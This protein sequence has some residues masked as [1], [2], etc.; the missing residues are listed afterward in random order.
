MGVA[1]FLEKNFPGPVKRFESNHPLINRLMK[2][3]LTYS[4]KIFLTEKLGASKFQKAVF[5]V[6]DIKYKV[7]KTVCPNY[8][9]YSDKLIDW[10]KRKKLKKLHSDIE[11]KKVIASANYQKK[12]SHKEFHREINR[13]YHMNSNRPLEIIRYLEWNKNVHKRGLKSDVIIICCLLIISCLGIGQAAIIIPFELFSAFINF[14]CVNIQ[15]HNIYRFKEKEDKLRKIQ[16]AQ[17]ERNSTKYA[18]ANKLI[19]DKHRE[20][21]DVPTIDDIISNVE[22]IE[23]LQQLRKLIEKQK[24]TNNM[25][26]KQ[27]G[28]C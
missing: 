13:N 5:K 24:S 3:E 17:I 22:T 21:E 12:I 15:N 1:E 14:Q 20:L 11:R 2:K 27:K 9:K 19:A 25:I 8:L 7:L 18:E 23:Q 6:E 26:A 4:D 28:K 16:E 10:Q